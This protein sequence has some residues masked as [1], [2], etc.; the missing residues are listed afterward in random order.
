MLT[1]KSGTAA[2]HPDRP[3]TVADLP[4]TKS[5][6]TH[7]IPVPTNAIVSLLSRRRNH[8][9]AR[10]DGTRSGLQP[11]QDRDAKAYN[12]LDALDFA[13]R[14]RR[15]RARHADDRETASPTIDTLSH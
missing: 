4:R 11:L 12:L 3:A 7:R 8:L 5:T 2:F 10:A 1:I 6:H 14:R 15:H 9:R 13:Q